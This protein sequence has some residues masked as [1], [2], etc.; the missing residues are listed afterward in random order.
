MIEYFNGIDELIQ[1]DP[2]ENPRPLWAEISYYKKNGG[3]AVDN[4]DYNTSE[5]LEVLRAAK[6]AAIKFKTDV[7]LAG[8]IFTYGGDTYNF[9]LTDMI[10]WTGLMQVHQLGGLAFP[11]KL[12]DASGKKRNLTQ[13]QFEDAHSAGFTAVK[14]TVD[15]DTDLKDEAENA[16]DFTELKAVVDPR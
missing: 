7:L 6:I 3:D 15:E 5:Q 10:V 13:G 16:S 1:T 12:Q 9:N 2:K 11:V 14:S 4:P 8:G